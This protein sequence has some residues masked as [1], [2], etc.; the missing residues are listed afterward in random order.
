[1]LTDFS[2]GPGT[3]ETGSRA[4]QKFGCEDRQT[5]KLEKRMRFE[6]KIY[7]EVQVGIEL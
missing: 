5:K 1:M 7:L 6:R 3:G 4:G 2:N